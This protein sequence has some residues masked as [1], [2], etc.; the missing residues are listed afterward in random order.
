MHRYPMLYQ[1]NTRVRLGEL[2]RELGRAATLDDLPDEDLRRLGELGFD[3]LWLLGVWRTGEAGRAV[4]RSHRE[5]R[6]DFA[7]TLPDLAEEDICGSCFAITGY[8]VAAGLGGNDA[9]ERLRSRL[10]EHG[11]RLMLDF[12]PNHVALDHPF[13]E[14]HPEFL[15]RGTEEDL[16]REPQNYVRRDGVIYAHGRDPYFDGWPDTLQLNF[17]EPALQEAML[18]DLSTIATQCDG[19]RCDMAMLILPDVFASTWGV[20]PEPFWPGAIEAVHATNSEFMFMAEVYWDLERKLQQQG[21]DYTYD[22]RLYDRLRNLDAGL[23]G[24]HLFADLAFQDRLV[25]FLENHDEPRAATTFPPRVHP[26]AAVVTYLVPGLRF[27]HQGQLKGRRQR[28]SPHLCRG[29]SEAVDVHL[30]EF[31]TKLLSCLSHPA[32]RDG[33]WQLLDSS[34]AVDGNDTSDG[35]IA[36]SWEGSD[37]S[38]LLVAVNYSSQ[39]SQ[40]RIALPFERLCGTMHRLTDLLGD[41]VYDRDGDELIDPGLYLD[42]P[43]WGYHAFEITG[44]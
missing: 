38:L 19:V 32:L 34:Q 12:V 40:C 11:L 41:A 5:W 36:F 23:V 15:I 30:R 33:D 44:P 9:L 35:F 6:Q 17:A 3:W 22:K 27:F 31:Y 16:A 13:V 18:A 10:H 20:R 21:F 37:G 7:R 39:A 42:L 25:R 24:E 1:L 2:S 4:S 14:A 8:E 43:P 28:I 26:A 29:P